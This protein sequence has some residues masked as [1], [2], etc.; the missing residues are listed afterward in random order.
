MSTIPLSEYPAPRTWSLKAQAAPNIPRGS[1]GMVEA[2]R[3]VLNDVAVGKTLNSP[4]DIPGST[5]KVTLGVCCQRLRPV[6][7]VRDVKGVWSL[8]GE[9]EKWRASGDNR[10][11]AA[12]LCANIKFMG[13]I[14][15][16]LSEPKKMVE[17]QTIANAQYRMPWKKTSEISRRLIWLRDLGLVE[18][19][20]YA[21]LYE[22]TKD[23]LDFLASITIES[24][25]SIIEK[26]TSA[27]GAVRQASRW[28]LS[29]C[30]ISAQ[31]LS[32]RDGT[33]GYYPGGKSEIVNTISAYVSY[34]EVARSKESIEKFAATN[35]GIKASSLESFLSMLT[36]IGFIERVSRENYAAT[37]IATTWNGSPNPLDLCCCVHANCLFT[38][39]ILQELE[40]GPKARMICLLRRSSNTDLLKRM[41][42]K[43]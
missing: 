11:L 35:Y 31:D 8:S 25:E 17:L 12:L 38:F 24:P 20:D 19:H 23:A 26:S 30:D 4:V 7:L 18:Y 34:L 43:Y 33:I 2:L 14:L 29:L 3:I 22:A 10:Y 42:R 41:A 27:D 9:A 28:A 15:N 1:V 6:G 5:S 21:L 36:K 13:E 37:K 16:L 39:E 40:N 32:R